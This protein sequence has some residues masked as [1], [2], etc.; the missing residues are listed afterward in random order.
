MALA[1]AWNLF[2]LVLNFTML[3]SFTDMPP[4][5]PADFQDQMQTMAVVMGIF[6]AVLGLGFIALH[7]W[8]IKRLVSAPVRREFGALA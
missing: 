2:G 1:I 3:G 7:G 5:T 6:S 8:L 4:G